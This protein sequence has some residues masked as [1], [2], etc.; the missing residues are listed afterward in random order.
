M[1]KYVC[2]L[3]I[4]YQKINYI[5]CMHIAKNASFA[6]RTWLPLINS[7]TAMGIPPGIP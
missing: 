6:V 3:P 7:I 1:A 2:K 4:V 5:Y